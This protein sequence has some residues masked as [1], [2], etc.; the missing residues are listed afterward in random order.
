MT[1]TEWRGG[2]LP[3]DDLDHVLRETMSLWQEARGARVFVT[4]GTGFFGG[5]I[6]QSFLSANQQLELGAEMVLLSRD[7]AAALQRM[8]FLRGQRAVTFHEGDARSCVTPAGHF[9]YV[10]HGATESSRQQHAGD[11]QH[12]FD[13]IVEGTR[14]ALHI[15]KASNA[16]AFLLLSSGAVYGPQPS[17][18]ERIDED[19]RG[20]PN[21]GDP[22]SA[23]AEAKRAAELLCSIEHETSGLSVRVARCFA[24]VGPGLPLDAHF[25]V[26]NFIGDALR[27]GPIRIRGNGTAVRSYLYMADLASWLWTLLLSPVASG[28]YNVGSEKAITILELARAVRTVCAPGV[29]IEVA[30]VSDQRVDPHRYVPS[31][32][33]ARSELGLQERF[34]LDDAIR[35]TFTWHAFGRGGVPAS[36]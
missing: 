31:T 13:T 9:D 6:V 35:R 11:H 8:P 34:V 18:I 12:M 4:G 3:H 7:P 30:T 29:G 15:A 22:R 33:R 19:F 21:P 32:V 26:G 5:W 16:R 20:G 25:A 2:P 27:G 1:E 10:L 14:R 28:A 17:N 23:Y 36:A 24:F